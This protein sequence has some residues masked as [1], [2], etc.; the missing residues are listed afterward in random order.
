MIASFH[1]R[2]AK[3]F[4][5]LFLMRVKTIT[6]QAKIHGGKLPP[7]K[8]NFCTHCGVSF[9][10]NT[11]KRVITAT[12]TNIF[13]IG[14]IKESWNRRIWNEKSIQVMHN[15]LPKTYHTPKIS[16]TGK[17]V[18][19]TFKLNKHFWFKFVKETD[20]WNK[21]TTNTGVEALKK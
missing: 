14:L 5:V 16:I 2:F 17:K 18:T 1:Q 11:I 19:F 8:L 3:K 12:P 4:L 13:V 9:I 10:T 15:L 7:V 6:T 21:F 20:S